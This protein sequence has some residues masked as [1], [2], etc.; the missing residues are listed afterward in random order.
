MVEIIA[1]IFI[2]AGIIIQCISLIPIHRLIARL[3]LGSV[4]NSW[5]VMRGMVTLFLV[6]YVAFGVLNWGHYANESAMVVPLIFLLGAA[7][8][9]LSSTLSLRTAIDVRRVTMLEQ[10]NVTDP[11]TGIFN[12][13]YLERRLH[14]EF[15]RAE[16]RS[17]PLSVLLIDIDHF[18]VVNDMYGH[19]LGDNL[20]V[21]LTKLVISAVRST[22]VMAR[23]GGDEFMIVAI[24]THA[25]TA[26]QL[27]EHICHTVNAHLFTLADENQKRITARVTIS[28]GVASY[29]ERVENV[30][31]LI[32][33]ADQ[34]MY[35]AKKDGRNRAYTSTDYAPTE[36]L[37]QQQ[38]Q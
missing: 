11:L 3:P 26:A 4:Q 1:N 30:A 31:S 35:Q 34:A 25:Q 29:H 23:Y 17:I 2:L 6:G 28:V 7:F 13:R 16:Q 36:N 9:W 38:G 21:E 15:A 5:M 37:V 10:E 22:D 20:L 24:N 27:A 12:R 14:E 8:V 18:K 32:R 33:C 19:P